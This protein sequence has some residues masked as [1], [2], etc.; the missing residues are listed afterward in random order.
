MG[1]GASSAKSAHYEKECVSPGNLCSKYSQKLKAFDAAAAHCRYLDEAL[2]SLKRDLLQAGVG[3][4][5]RA[6]G[7]TAARPSSLDVAARAFTPAPFVADQASETPWL[8][9]PNC[10]T[11]L[12]VLHARAPPRRG[13]QR[14]LH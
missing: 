6:H 1:G 3:Q 7:A 11:N 5:Q 13:A 4:G 10:L 14:R 8:Q 2:S 9:L 12:P